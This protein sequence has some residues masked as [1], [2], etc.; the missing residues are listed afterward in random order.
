MFA[1]P[2]QVK[3]RYANNTNETYVFHGPNAPDEPIGPVKLGQPYYDCGR[4]DKWSVPAMSPIG[5]CYLIM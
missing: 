3:I 5:G 1:C 2:P 4:S